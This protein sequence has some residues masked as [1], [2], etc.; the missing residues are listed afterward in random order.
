MSGQDEL[1]FEPAEFSGRARLFPLPNLVLFPHVIQPLH[2]FEP[3]YR[4]LMQDALLGDKLITMALLAPG[5]ARDAAG[6]PAIH[7]VCCLGRILRHER[8]ADGCY[9]LLLA[10]LRRVKIERELD[11]GRTF[12]EAEVSVCEDAY[13]PQGAEHRDALRRRL[14]HELRRQAGSLAHA[15]E[16][17]DEFDRQQLSLG[18]L[19]DI[20]AYVVDIDVEVKETLLS[21]ID[22]DRRA[23][24]LLKAMMLWA[25]QPSSKPKF[26][27]DFSVN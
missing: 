8:L 13:A 5:E 7:Q 16:L 15:S 2:V 19:T 12:R 26:P 23:R 4:E 22:V 20:I 1:G 27:P 14:L 6:R 3:R 21:E 17:F 25:P 10:G 9:N 18:V 11:T 24:L